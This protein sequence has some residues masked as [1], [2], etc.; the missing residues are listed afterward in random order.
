MLSQAPGGFREADLSLVH[1]CKSLGGGAYFQPLSGSEAL[2]HV[3]H[4]VDIA[5]PVA[6]DLPTLSSSRT[7]SASQAALSVALILG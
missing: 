2:T 3:R 1:L 4:R 7:L 5:A 6:L